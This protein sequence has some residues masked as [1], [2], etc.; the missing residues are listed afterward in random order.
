MMRRPPV[1]GRNFA[2]L[3]ARHFRAA[4]V[5]LDWTQDELARRASV[6]RRTI[7]MLESGGCR[8]QP[9]KVRA[10]VA[11]LDAGG[12]RFACD[13]EGEVSLIDG[14]AGYDPTTSSRRYGSKLAE[15]LRTRVSSRHPA[16][17]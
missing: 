1:E 6:A 7:V 11:A 9:G 8:T 13:A 15:R 5:L 2:Y 16:A 12:I 14:N 3:R 4:R 17:V 10:V